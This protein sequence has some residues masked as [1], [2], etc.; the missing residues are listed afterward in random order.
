LEGEVKLRHILFNRV[1]S[2][3]GFIVKIRTIEG[4]VQ[5]REGDRVAIVSVERVMGKSQTLLHKDTVI[6][7]NPP[8]D[9]EVIV[10]EKRNEILQNVIEAMRFR[11]YQVEMV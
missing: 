10:P 8:H 3:A 4:F 5:Y 2:D 1:K 9:T 6:K 11:K 7:W